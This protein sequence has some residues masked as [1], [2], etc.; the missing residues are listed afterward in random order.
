[1]KQRA[2]F[3]YLRMFS[4][5]LV[6]A[7]AGSI[8]VRAQQNLAKEVAIP[9]WVKGKIDTAY[10]KVI[11]YTNGDDVV[12]FPILTD[13]H[14]TSS[15]V[16]DHINYALYA[17]RLMTYDF[18]VNLGDIGLDVSTETPQAASQLMRDVYDRHANFRGV[19]L[20]AY[21]NHDGNWKYHHVPEEEWA[22]RFLIPQARKS[23][24]HFVY[25]KTYSYYDVE[26]TKTRVIVL[27][28]SDGN[29]TEK[30]SN[31]YGMSD[32]QLSWFASALQL[33]QK[34]W[35]VIILTHFCANKIGDWKGYP[36]HMENSDIFEAIMS[37]FKSKTRGRLRNVSW[38]FSTNQSSD[39]VANFCGD[40]HF[41][42]EVKYNGVNRIITQ[43]YGGVSKSDVPE[44]GRKWDRGS[45]MI[46]DIVV[47]KP[48][49]KE[50]KMFRLGA[51]EDR[52]F[53]Y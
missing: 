31:Y 22:S 30:S 35:N 10:E 2:L 17:D 51:G 25:H 13:L 53:T 28:T 11:K 24:S 19:T 9:D 14:L 20:F 43:G 16:Y 6:L 8:S 49:K 34:G 15:G 3:G 40:S 21:G 38:D 52:F 47:L 5:L 27:N 37:G 44:G 4:A 29:N 12:I 33:R 32:E 26:R 18:V 48:K 7:L 39:I 45:D 1:M 41:D 36:S 23:S 46:I 50:F 42:N